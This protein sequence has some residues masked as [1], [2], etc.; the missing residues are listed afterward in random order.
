M[1]PSSVNV[2]DFCAALQTASTEQPRRLTLLTDHF[3]RFAQW[4]LILFNRIDHVSDLEAMMR[5][6]MKEVVCYGSFGLFRPAIYSLRSFFELSLAWTYY[7]DHRLEWA[8][9]KT[10]RKYFLTPGAVEVELRDCYAYL[11]G[12]WGAMQSKPGRSYRPYAQLSRYVHTADPNLLPDLAKASDLVRDQHEFAVLNTLTHDVA[13]YVWDWYAAIY[14]PE[15]WL[16]MPHEMRQE[17]TKRVPS[18]KLDEFRRGT[19]RPADRG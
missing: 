1:K 18:E 4:E 7:S 13:S 15:M 3:T 10:D 17:L 2:A 5:I 11:P 19:L 12:N 6:V 14:T 9:C 8:A 16:S